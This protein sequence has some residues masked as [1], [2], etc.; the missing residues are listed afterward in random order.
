MIDTSDNR[1]DRMYLTSFW[2]ELRYVDTDYFII[3]NTVDLFFSPK[4]KIYE[5][6]KDEKENTL[7]NS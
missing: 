6:I 7:N 4:M 3:G 1:T 2:F 5:F